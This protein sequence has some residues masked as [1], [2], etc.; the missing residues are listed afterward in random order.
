MRGP[1]ES[2]LQVLMPSA[3]AQMT[4]AM[5][6]ADMMPSMPL[7]TSGDCTG[8]MTR[9]GRSGEYLALIPESVLLVPSVDVDVDVDASV[10]K[11]PNP[12]AAVSVPGW[13]N[14]AGEEKSSG[15]GAMELLPGRKISEM[16]F[17]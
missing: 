17:E 3:P 2:P 7:Q 14:C 1:P 6:A 12:T 8:I 13:P 9:Y 4:L 11:R 15:A 5:L 10:N 16:S